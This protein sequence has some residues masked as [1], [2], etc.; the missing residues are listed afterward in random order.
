MQHAFVPSAVDAGA[1]ALHRARHADAGGARTVFTGANVARANARI[2]RLMPHPKFIG[3]NGAAAD[4]RA[5]R[6]VDRAPPIV[7]AANSARHAK[8]MA[9]FVDARV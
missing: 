8:R 2:K 1:H 9:R 7:L 6:L 5:A 3:G 4:R